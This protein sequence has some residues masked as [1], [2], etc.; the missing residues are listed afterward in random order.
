MCSIRLLAKIGDPY[1]EPT[2]AVH[3][4]ILQYTLYT[5][6]FCG[7]TGLLQFV[8]KLLQLHRNLEFRWHSFKR[9]YQL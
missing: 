2:I 1:Y 7:C 8:G 3:D 9:L 6:N 4:T 5:A